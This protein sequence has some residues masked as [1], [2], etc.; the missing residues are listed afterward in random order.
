MLV[1]P[2]QITPAITEVESHEEPSR[3]VLLR[4]KGRCVSLS[5]RL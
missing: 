3:P 1:V 5:V 2:F 4:Y